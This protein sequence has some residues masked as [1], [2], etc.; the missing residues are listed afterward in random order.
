MIIIIDGYNLL[1]QHITDRLITEQERIL[2]IGQMQRYAQRKKHMIIVV[3]DGGPS[4]WLHK[5]QSG[6]VT[7]LYS[8]AYK[9]ADDIIKQYLEDYKNKDVLLVSA[10]RDLTDYAVYLDIVSIDPSYF[11]ELVQDTLKDQELGSK[12]EERLEKTTQQ[13]DESLDKVMLAFSTSVPVKK[14]DIKKVSFITNGR[15][16]SKQERMLIE[17]LKKL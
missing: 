7:E 12:S 15:K 8:G 4:D 16:K 2:F 5:S 9:T 13:D 11:Y 17:K 1:K 10:D 3:F 14:E 6:R